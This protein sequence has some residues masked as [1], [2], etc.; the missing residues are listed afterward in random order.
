MALSNRDRIDR[1]LDAVKRGLGPYVLRELKSRYGERWPYAVASELDGR[2]YSRVQNVKSE[3]A[4]L[5]AAD[6]QA[7]LK[8]TWGSYNEVFNDK[9]GFSGRNYLSEVMDA[10]NSWAHGGNF[11]VEETGRAL[12]TMHLLL[13]AISAAPEAEGAYLVQERADVRLVVLD[14]PGEQGL[15]FVAEHHRPV[16]ALA[17]VHADPTLVVRDHLRL[18]SYEPRP[19][20]HPP[21]APYEAKSFRRSL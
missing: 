7:L 1:G 21:T 13:R 10:R 3:D 16:E 6:A 2:A 5:E 4:F 20:T 15:P 12:D 19:R 11:S 17:R 18:S 8:L 14:P 9:L